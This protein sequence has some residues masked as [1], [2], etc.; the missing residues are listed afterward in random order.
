MANCYN[1]TTYNVNSKLYKW[2]GNTFE[3]YQSLAA[4][5]AMDWEAFSIEGAYYLAVANFFNSEDSGY[6]T[7]SLIYKWDNTTSNFVPYQSIPTNG[8]FDWEYFTIGDD[9][10]LAVAN[11]RNKSTCNINSRVYKWN[12]TAFDTAHAQ[13]IATNGALHWT[14]F[15]IGADHF[16]AVANSNSTSTS[17]YNINSRIYWWNGTDFTFF[18][19]VPTHGAY[20]WK[21]FFIGSEH[22]LAVADYSDDSGLN[23]LSR[24]YK[25][26]Y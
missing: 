24:I 8:A 21:Y 7:D 17:T 19:A 1:G 18:Q 20:A 2:N 15:T 22:F 10:F 5:G 11:Y 16:L 26:Q 3:F 13:D 14:F 23:V 4:Y 6:N 12:G 9:R 25:I